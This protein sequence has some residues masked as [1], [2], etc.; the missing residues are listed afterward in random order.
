LLANAET[1]E[2]YIPASRFHPSGESPVIRRSLLL[3]CLLLPLTSLSWAE[4]PKVVEVPAGSFYVVK[5][6]NVRNGNFSVTF[7]TSKDDN[8]PSGIP[9][10]RVYNSLSEHQSSYGLG[11]GTAMD[12]AVSFL[13]DGRLGIKENGTGDFTLYRLKGDSPGQE[14]VST[15]ATEQRYVTSAENSAR[16]SK[17]KL[18]QV[19]VKNGTIPDQG[20]I[21]PLSLGPIPNGSVFIIENG[22]KGDV[23]RERSEI[24]REGD[25]MIRVFGNQCPTVS[26]TY[27]LQGALVHVESRQ[28]RIGASLTTTR[29]PK[30][31][32]ITSIT[33]EKGKTT[34]FQYDAKKRLVR[35][36][37]PGGIWQ[38]FEYD[39]RDNMTAILY[40]DG[41]KQTLSYDAK[42]RALSVIPRRGPSA[43]FE[44]LQDP[45]DPS[46]SI[47]R[48]TI[49]EG[50]Q[51]SVTVFKLLN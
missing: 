3:S 51:K 37:Y 33:D 30:T 31:K 29:N 44:Y 48:V 13:D 22:F 15:K 4:A 27:T 12:N 38:G 8:D 35:Q 11:W 9:F 32:L 49:S 40:L 14:Y 24:R 28:S 10:D 5:G 19:L 23:C 47:T 39:Q 25:R 36:D 17:E 43:N 21:E 50:D 26:E 16:A 1:C 45:Y 46:V 18:R 20:P 7:S 41:S 34:R 6:V 2:K 42:N